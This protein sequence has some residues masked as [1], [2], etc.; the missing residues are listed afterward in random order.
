MTDQNV[1][2][3]TAK[4]PR[5]RKP[6]ASQQIREELKHDRFLRLGTK[7]MDSLLKKIRLVGNL[8]DGNYEYSENEK[9]KVLSALA[10]AVDHVKRRFERKIKQAGFT[11]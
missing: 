5:K 6:R 4:P 10:D 7:R 9:Q 11:F 8:G 3:I 2:T 1:A